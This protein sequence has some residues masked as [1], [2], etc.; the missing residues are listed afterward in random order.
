MALYFREIPLP[1][2]RK[3][4]GQ[5][6]CIMFRSL[7]KSSLCAMQYNSSLPP[8][9]DVTEN[10]ACVNEF[11]KE[12]RR[13]K[14]DKKENWY[15][16]RWIGYQQLF[17]RTREEDA[18]HK[19][20][21]YISSYLLLNDGACQTNSTPSN[22]WRRTRVWWAVQI[23]CRRVAARLNLMRYTIYHLSHRKSNW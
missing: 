6:F 19:W 2:R 3:N 9:S 8:T 22:K 20:D 21:K 15:Y 11:T 12:L 7:N 5:M 14:S 17:I 1:N 10:R 16:K 18:W 13:R 4:K 23:C